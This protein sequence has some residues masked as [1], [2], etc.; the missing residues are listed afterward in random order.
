MVEHSASNLR[1]KS[2]EKQEEAINITI[3]LLVF[4]NY[5][6]FYLLRERELVQVEESTIASSRWIEVAFL[7][8]IFFL[9]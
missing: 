7:H 8:L 1:K 3:V 2:W 9:D 5:R 6:G 4:P